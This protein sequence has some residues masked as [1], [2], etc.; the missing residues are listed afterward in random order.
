MSESFD[1]GSRSIEQ[2]I[3]C[4]NSEYYTTADQVGKIQLPPSI[5]IDGEKYIPVRSLHLEGN[6]VD[7]A[8]ELKNDDSY[9]FKIYTD[10]KDLSIG[11]CIKIS[12]V[13][14]TKV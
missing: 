10:D 8:Y 1:D 13:Y 2:N 3:V 5:D 11:T 14:Y 12:G 4:Q 7:I 9:L 6:I